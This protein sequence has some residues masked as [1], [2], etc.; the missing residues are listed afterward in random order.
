MRQRFLISLMFRS[1]GWMEKREGKKEGAKD[2]M[3][4]GPVRDEELKLGTNK[5]RR[6]S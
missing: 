1:R 5:Q 2:D 3:H 4:A 6:K